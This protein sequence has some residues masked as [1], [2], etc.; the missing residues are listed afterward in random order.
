MHRLVRSKCLANL[1]MNAAANILSLFLDLDKVR[2]DELLP[3][4]F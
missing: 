1:T 4:N 3:P 2:I